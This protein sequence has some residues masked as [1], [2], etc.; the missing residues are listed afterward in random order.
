[1]LVAFGINKNL[2]VSDLQYGTCN[3]ILLRC[4]LGFT[5]LKRF[6]G[7]SIKLL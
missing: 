1:M 6:L 4:P 2:N 3:I 7:I 5:G